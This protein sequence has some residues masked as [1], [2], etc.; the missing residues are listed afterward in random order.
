MA[1]CFKQSR[2]CSDNSLSGLWLSKANILAL[3]T[4][5]LVQSGVCYYF[6]GSDNYSLFC[7]GTLHNGYSSVANC[8]DAACGG[9]SCS[10]TPIACTALPSSF[11]VTGWAS[12]ATSACALCTFDYTPAPTWT[13]TVSFLHSTPNCTYYGNTNG[14]TFNF[15]NFGGLS[16]TVTLTNNVSGA[17][18][19]CPGSSGCV[20]LPI[21]NL[22]FDCFAAP[23][24]LPTGIARWSGCNPCA[25]PRNGSFV[26]CTTGFDCSLGPTSMTLS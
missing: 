16:W 15:V 3:G 18:G 1:C 12:L 5:T 25:D 4:L 10:T 11:L 22:L 2:K 26:Q 8:A 13:G 19:F 24:G 14:A 6:S 17:A 20:A 21:W 9:G 7:H 23:H